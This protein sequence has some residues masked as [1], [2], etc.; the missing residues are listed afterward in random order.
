MPFNFYVKAPLCIPLCFAILNDGKP[1]Y[2]WQCLVQLK[3]IEASSSWL[4]V[5]AKNDVAQQ[6][7]HE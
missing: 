2:N 1:K 4:V 7:E 3:I 5:D 6:A